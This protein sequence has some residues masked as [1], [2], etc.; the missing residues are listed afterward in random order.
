MTL[1]FIVPGPPVGKQRARVTRQGHAYTPSKTVNYEAL[2]KQTFA[3]KYPGHVPWAHSVKMMVT[4]YFQIPKSAPK[5]AQLLMAT[6]RMWYPHRI[7]G[8]NLW[9]IVADALNGLAYIDDGQVVSG[10]VDKFYS[11]RPR[12]R[13]TLEAIGPQTISRGEAA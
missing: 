13:V 6:E 12:L 3:A 11:S 10:H 8:D 7:D 4:A 2:I 1:Q 9:K 5:K